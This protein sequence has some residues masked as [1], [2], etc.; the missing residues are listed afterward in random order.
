MGLRDGFS[1]NKLLDDFAV[2]RSNLTGVCLPTRLKPSSS[3]IR[4]LKIDQTSRYVAY[5][6]TSDHMMSNEY[7]VRLKP[8]K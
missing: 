3:T 6:K 1:D 8:S 5:Q 7:A 2:G 4:S